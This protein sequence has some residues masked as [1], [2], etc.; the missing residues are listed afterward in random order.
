MPKT[1]IEVVSFAYRLDQDKKL[2]HHFGDRP[3]VVYDCRHLPNPHNSEL[4][5]RDGRDADVKAFVFDV[6]GTSAKAEA[7]VRRAIAEAASSGWNWHDTPVLAFGCIGGK[8]RSVAVAEVT[9][10][11]LRT[12]HRFKGQIHPNISHFGLK[13]VGLA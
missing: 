13:A 9:H 3:L 6:D 5:D 7:V 11:M 4:R 10:T 2:H 8:H 12:D 1:Q